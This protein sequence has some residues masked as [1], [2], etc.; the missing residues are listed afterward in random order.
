MLVVLFGPPAAGKTTLANALADRL[1]ADA[2]V[3]HSDDYRRDTYRRLLADAS[4]LL[5]LRNVVL[6]DGTFYEPEWR[7]RA[8]AIADD[9]FLAS[10]TADLDTC[11]RRDRARNGIGEPGVRTIHKEF[12]EQ[13]VDADLTID[14]DILPLDTALDILESRLEDR[15]DDTR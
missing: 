14:T 5:D 9:S 4:D 3:L 1:D 6:C 13:D 15:F 2:P 11:L 12:R 8:R 7:D 10:V